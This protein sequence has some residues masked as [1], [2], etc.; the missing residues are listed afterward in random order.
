[1][2]IIIAIPPQAQEAAFETEQYKEENRELQNQ[3]RLMGEEQETL[4]V[5][6]EQTGHVLDE[7]NAE[8]REKEEEL[9]KLQAALAGKEHE[10]EDLKTQRKPLFVSLSLSL[11][12]F[13]KRRPARITLPFLP[14]CICVKQLP[15]QRWLRRSCKVWN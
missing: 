8:I 3:L 10:I 6:L 9:G 12:L 14:C 1:M 13:V 15:K 7:A 2:Y 5:Q 4:T 11:S